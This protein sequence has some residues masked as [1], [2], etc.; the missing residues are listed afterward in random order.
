MAYKNQAVQNAANNIK[1]NYDIVRQNAQN[2]YK[3]SLIHI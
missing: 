2:A 1:T 3:L